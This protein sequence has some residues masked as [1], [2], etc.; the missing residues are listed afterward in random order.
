MRKERA[1]KYAYLTVMAVAALAATAQAQTKIY[2]CGNSY[3]NSASEAQAKG[4]KPMDGGNV[5]V[6]EGTRVNSAQVKVAT[7]PSSVTPQRINADEQKARDNDA[8]AI[9]EAE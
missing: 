4:C 5:T 8:R 6:V 9:L 7:A 2:R 1:M 3:T